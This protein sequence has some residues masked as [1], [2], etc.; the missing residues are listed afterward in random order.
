MAKLQIP[1]ARTL[2]KLRRLLEASRD[3]ATLAE[4]GARVPLKTRQLAYYSV[5]AQIL[6]LAKARRDGLEVT[7]GGR[8]LLATEPG[9]GEEA[10]AWKSAIEGSGAIQEVAP[11]LFNA[12]P[13]RE[14]E[15]ALRIARLAGLAADTARSRAG[16]LLRWREQ[17][18]QGA[19][20]S[21]LPLSRLAAP[22]YEGA[23]V[24][25]SITIASFKAFGEAKER[26]I[27]PVMPLTVF[28]GPNGAG[29]STILQ[30]VDLLGAL[31]RGNINEM[32][33][34]HSWE[35]ADLP[36]LRAPSQTLSVEVEVE[37]EGARLRWQLTLG[38]RRYAGIAGEL[39][40]VKHA[41]TESY[42]PLL[43]RTGRSVTLYDE[44]T[45]ERRVLPKMTLPQSWLSTLDDKEDAAQHPG[46]L[47]LKAWAEGIH[48]FWTLDPSVLR[49]PSTADGE[50]LGSRG[51][52][53]ASF[54][55]RLKRTRPER[56]AS[57]LERVQRHYPRLVS[58]E[59]RVKP[60]GAKSL[61]ITEK[62]NGEEATFNARQVSDGLLR[63]MVLAAVPEWPSPP[64]VV[65]LD[66][67]D[68]GLHPRLIG[69]IARLLADISK[70]TQV[71]ATTHSPITLNYVP[72]ASSRLVT[73]GRGGR[74]LVTRLEDTHNY[75][76]LREH[77]EPGELWYN[78]G[79]ERLVKGVKREK[80][81]RS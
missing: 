43:D 12:A 8:Q 76:K 44:R 49:S 42:R 64:T 63:M 36:H 13:P 78:A 68:N 14:Q 34:V 53:L 18:L 51:E 45:G 20:Q 6:G 32:L 46:L 65:L 28:A 41:G 80:G 2:P 21:V 71:L 15:L 40:E 48:P 24:L 77:F 25:R 26:H 31:V 50:R 81:E 29:K 66:E 72:A 30:A 19:G 39:V 17:V 58:V 79:E 27:I 70:T 75:E 16:C 10:A 74:V 52:H 22:R 61:D 1:Q 57:F 47:A 60:N 11:D 54:L 67:L 7:A 4:A 73:R 56:F 55:H 3:A 62:W 23:V 35:Y 38:S 69:G 33:K 5:A 59:P 9:S 37:V